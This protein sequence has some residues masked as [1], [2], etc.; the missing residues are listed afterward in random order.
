[1]SEN[2]YLLATVVCSSKCTLSVHRT[3]RGLSLNPRTVRCSRCLAAFIKSESVITSKVDFKQFNALK[4][5]RVGMPTL[6]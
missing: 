5:D 6:Q 1:M 4:S 3:V 2:I